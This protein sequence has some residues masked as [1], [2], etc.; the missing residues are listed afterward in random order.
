[1]ANITVKNL[2]DSGA[3][4]F[5]DG[6]RTK[7]SE[8]GVPGYRI[9]RVAD[10]AD[11]SVET[12]GP[13]FVRSEFATMMREKLSAPDDVLLTTKGTVGRV[14][15]FPKDA[16]QMV[17]S[18][19]LCYFRVLDQEWINSRY[20]AYWFKSDAFRLQALDRSNNTD[21]APY[22]NMRDIRSL[23]IDLPEIKEQRAIAE[24]L[25]AL[26]DKIAANDRVAS[27]SSDLALALFERAAQAAKAFVP[28][29]ELVGT[30][31]GL[32]ASASDVDGLRFVRVTDINKRP[33]IEWRETP[34]CEISA[35]DEEK[36]FL[37]PGDL[38]VARM[39]DPGKAAIIDEGDPPAVFASYLVRLTP[40]NPEMARY[41]YYFLESP[42]YRRYANMVASGSVQKN[43]NARVIVGA[44]MPMPDD[45]DLCR[46]NEVV[47]PLRSHLSSTVRQN[48]QLAQTRD[49]LLP[50]LMSGKIRVRD[51][52]KTAEE[53]L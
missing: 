40:K 12:T 45:D 15:M 44:D 34:G 3:L 41:I 37:R 32:T 7:R 33:W 36:Y 20:L 25:G 8:L 50:L 31:Y 43:M 17:Y 4:T 2:A 46:F 48:Q 13:D 29:S 39:A 47:L 42:R 19:Q 22:I 27:S 24:V 23:V 11:W 35:A 18:P 6:Y 21:M 14:A 26:D 9:L 53:V 28:L 38:L 1:M 52:E 5:S 16:E 30:Q 51:A 49:E 10:V